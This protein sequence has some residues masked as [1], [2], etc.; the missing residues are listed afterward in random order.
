MRAPAQIVT[1]ARRSLLLLAILLVSRAPLSAQKSPIPFEQ[2]TLRALKQAVTFFHENAASHGGYVYYYS[3]DLQERWGE[4]KASAD[5]IFVQPPGTPTVGMA[6]LVAHAATRDPLYL[7]VARQAAEAL[8]NGQLESGG[9]T[10]TIHF[11]PD[12]RLGKYRKRPGGNWNVS[13][14][15]DG[16]TQA[17]LRFLMRTDAALQCKHAGIHEA[18]RY[19]LDALLKAQF[20]NG[21]F[22]QVWTAPVAAHPVVKARFPDYDWRTEGR[23]KNYWDCYTLNDNLAGTV[24][25]TL[26]EARQIYQDER[27]KTAL[28]KLGDFLLLAQMPDPQPAWCQQYNYEMLPIWARKFEP[29]AVTG[30]E[31]QDV[32]KTL[33]K[34][35]GATNDR[36]YLEPIPRA[37]EYLRRSLLPDGRIARYYELRTNRPLYMDSAY[38]LTYDDSD[39]PAHY[40]WKQSAHLDKIALAYEQAKGG[41]WPVKPRDLKDLEEDARKIVAALDEKGRWIS[42]YA[43]ESLVGQPKFAPSFPYLSSAVFSRNA[44]ILSDYLRL[45]RERP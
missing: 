37:L 12:K 40:G 24:A 43:G 26:I 13:S 3:L 27:C 25:D 22:P 21:A 9:W 33:I 39:A 30:W 6:C 10:Q 15:D 45:A 17:A 31:S 2:E 5:T 8:V 20:P 28:A 19:A 14:L 29:P 4:G 18:A 11:G 34:I 7:D 32:I 44:E 42:N 36:K 23:I 1:L 41:A 35:A 16:Q 38:R